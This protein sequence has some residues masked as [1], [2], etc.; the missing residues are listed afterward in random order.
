ME[1]EDAEEEKMTA[2]TMMV[3]QQSTVALL[4]YCNS[5]KHYGQAHHYKLKVRKEASYLMLTEDLWTSFCQKS[6]FVL[7]CF[8]TE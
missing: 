4:R 3:L 8:R 6:P 5:R 1:E 2:M 7:Y